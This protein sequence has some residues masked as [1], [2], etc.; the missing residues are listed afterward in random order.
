MS[1]EFERDVIEVLLCVPNGWLIIHD[2]AE[3]L[4]HERIGIACRLANAERDRVVNELAAIGRYDFDDNED[5]DAS[6]LED[7]Y[8]IIEKSPA[9][10]K[11]W[12]GKPRAKKNIRCRYCGSPEH[13]AQDAICAKDNS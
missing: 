3:L 4:G 8:R 10:R 1:P 12:F 2:T 11:E 13:R 9:L 6:C 7:A 5:F